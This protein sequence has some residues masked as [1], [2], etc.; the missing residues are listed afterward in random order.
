M[1]ELSITI[2]AIVFPGQ[3]HETAYRTAHDLLSRRAP[4]EA[5]EVLEPA[6]AEDPGNRGVRQLTAWA[7]MLRVQLSKAEALLRELVEEAPDDVWARHA[8]GRVLERQSR[9][10]E[11]LPHLKLAAVMSDD[12]DHRAAVDRVARDVE[13][14]S[15][16]SPAPPM[17]EE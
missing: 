11:A 7:L 15:A 2:P 8:L 13:R 12:D 4:A 14:A 9:P 17:L 1:E 10:A 3:R 6:L 5:L 16:R